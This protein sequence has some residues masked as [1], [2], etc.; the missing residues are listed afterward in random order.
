[1]PLPVDQWLCAHLA[2]LWGR[3]PAI[4]FMVKEGVSIGIIGGLWYGAALFA[5]WS[6]GAQQGCAQL[7]RRTLTIAFASVLVAALTIVASHLVSWAPPSAHPALAALYDER[8]P[9]SLEAN[10]FPS[11][12]TALYAVVAAG[13]H[14]LRRAAG[15]TLWLGV[16]MLVALPRLYL[17]SHY[18]TDVVAGLILGLLAYWVAKLVEVGPVARVETIFGSRCGSLKRT[19]A[20]S[21]VFLWILEVATEFSHVIRIKDVL[22]SSLLG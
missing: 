18:L 4:D 2:A 8:V 14:S 17:G 15:C 20:E 11:Q 12:G 16:A 19:L 1:M 7:R 3:A 22:M 6:E 5:M 21:A 13:V 9:V 10:S